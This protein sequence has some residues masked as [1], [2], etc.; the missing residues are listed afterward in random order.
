MTELEK[1]KKILI[2]DDEVESVGYLERILLRQ[3]YDVISAN[4]GTNAIDLAQGHLPDLIILDI[5]LPDMEGSE[6]AA[7]LR[8]NPSTKDIPIIVVSG[9]VLCKE[10]QTQNDLPGCKQYVLAKPI[11]PQ[12]IIEL[13]AKIL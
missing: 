12:E 7:K 3:N 13:I 10:D 11:T 5:I 2:V 1:R 6:V 4:N 9:V 8:E